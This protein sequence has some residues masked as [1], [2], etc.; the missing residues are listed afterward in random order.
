[1]AF[2]HP[3]AVRVLVASSA[4]VWAGAA[5]AQA[6]STQDLVGTWNLTLTS[7][8]GSHP[9]T[10]VIK[11]DAGELVGEMTGLPIVGRVKVATSDTGV[12]LSFAVDH[13]GQPVDILLTGK[14]TGTE[15]KGT[16]DYAGGAATGD[17]NGTKSGAAPVS[18]S[19]A[20]AVSL[21]GTW[22]LVSTQS[23]AGWTMDLAQEG[24]KVTGTLRNAGQGIE[25]PLKGTHENGALSLDVGGDATGTI[26][27][28]F[29]GD[30]LKGRYDVGGN[31]GA[32]SA[33]RKP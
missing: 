28:S 2:F 1:M 13:E 17:F 21:T 25:M 11:E 32:W 19:A 24:T 12:T 5:Y 4:L 26:K 23:S 14:V 29:E 30:V 31:A 7:P 10:V 16:V 22:I 6:P 9:T 18:A 27:G 8:Q 20:G 3:L 33:T 15:I